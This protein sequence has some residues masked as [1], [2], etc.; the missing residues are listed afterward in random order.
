MK[1]SHKDI[2]N[3]GALLGYEYLRDGLCAGFSGMWM[4]AVFA[5]EEQKF[6]ERIAF[7]AT[8]KNNF[9]KLVEEINKAKA[10]QGKNINKNDI[11]LLDIIC[12]FDGIVLYLH[13]FMHTDYFPESQY[14]NQSDIKAIS[15]LVKPILMEN[16]EIE[17]LLDK[18]YVFSKQSLTCFFNDLAKKLDETLLTA[19][20]L[21]TSV[22]HS[23]C[24]KY[25]RQKSCWHYVDTNDF[26]RFFYTET[27]FRELNTKSLVDSVFESFNSR[28]YVALNTKLLT[29]NK[30]KSLKYC[31][32]KL[33]L[34][35]PI[36]AEQINNGGGC[37]NNVSI[38]SLACQHGHTEIATELLKSKHK[39]D[40]NKANNNGATPFFLACQNGHTEIV[41][42]LLKPE[43]KTDINK[44]Y[45]TGATPFFFACQNG[46][47]EIVK[48]L[49]KPEYKT[50]INKAHNTGATPFFLACQNGHTEIVKELLKPEHETD[51]NKAN[52]TGA[53]PFLLACQNGHTEIVTELLKP[54][55]KIDIN[56]ANND[57]ATPFLSASNNGHIEIV[58]ELLKPEHK[59]D[60]NKAYNTGAT[61][62]YFAC[63]NGHTEIVKELLKPEHKIDINKANNTGATP[64][65]FACQ[66]GHTEIVK[67]L[68]KPEHE[69]DI[70]KANNT[71]ATP[72]LFACQNGHIEIV[73]ELLKPEHKID[74]NKA[75]NTGATPFFLACQNGHTEIV[76]ELFASPNFNLDVTDT[77]VAVIKGY[78]HLLISYLALKIK[79]KKD[80]CYELVNH[81]SNISHTMMNMVLGGFVSSSGIAAIAIAFTVLNAA[82]L[83][84]DGLVL[85]GAGVTATLYGIGLFAIS[86]Y[87]N[88][89][90]EPP[91]HQDHIVTNN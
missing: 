66:N 91:L 25:D 59:T 47:T 14:V 81:G 36:G 53:T 4:Q 35:Y 55:H 15:S 37:S 7:I 71:G 82:T 9:P 90:Y 13:P 86:G 42:E 54:E 17:I 48:E 75:S 65:F 40:I 70:N 61:P 19:P 16:D 83:D 73:K 64:F 76:K 58:K 77:P 1:I 72:F 28:T 56:K 78:N 26:G 45:N 89:S 46:H 49:L 51:I 67:E 5:K 41:K 10:K 11:R 69:T 20:I 84:T 3:I 68:L 38:L 85:A 23:V 18:P 32:Q 63:Q 44:A 29:T 79:E 88:N 62:F 52:N 34:N 6:Y 21:L 31:M 33:N 8:F 80:L 43:Y 22:N 60:I 74:I 27:Y 24:L 87:K 30:D 2:I 57:G 12:F 50:D 39:T